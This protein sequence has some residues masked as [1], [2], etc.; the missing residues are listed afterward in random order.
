MLA[1]QTNLVVVEP[2]LDMQ[3]SQKGI[4]P[5]PLHV[6]LNSL[7][8]IF[9]N[10]YSCSEIGIQKEQVDMGRHPVIAQ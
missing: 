2:F 5:S 8:Y 7:H 4:N 9:S 1:S 10:I 3:E 6:S